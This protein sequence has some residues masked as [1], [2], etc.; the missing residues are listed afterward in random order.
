MTW[1]EYAKIVLGN[2][3]VAELKKN[4]ICVLKNTH[5]EDIKNLLIG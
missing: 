2:K 1:E 5:M 3:K 4:I